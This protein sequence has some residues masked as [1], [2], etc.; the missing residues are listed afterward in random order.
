MTEVRK[1]RRVT[2]RQL[3]LKLE[4]AGHP[5]HYSSLSQMATG[6]RR[7]DVDDLVALADVLDV[8]PSDLLES[9]DSVT[10]CV[11]DV[12]TVRYRDFSPRLQDPAPKQIEGEVLLDDPIY[13]RVETA[14]DTYLI[15]HVNV[16]SIRTHH[17][18]EE[19]EQ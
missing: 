10:T 19:S 14:D 18:P 5:I 16:I 7:I 9:S 11:A 1:Q 15:P 17:E 13:L 2:L 12:T 8:A 4:A 6:R 3:A